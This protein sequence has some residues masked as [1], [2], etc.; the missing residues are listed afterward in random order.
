M[1]SFKS[2]IAEKIAKEIG[3]TKVIANVLP[4]EKANTIKKSASSYCR[5]IER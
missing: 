2:L 3:I 5:G 4:A 1:I